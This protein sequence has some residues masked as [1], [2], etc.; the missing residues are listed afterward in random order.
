[1]RRRSPRSTRTDT[2]FPYT[3]LF[4]S[5]ARVAIVNVGD[6]RAYRLS[7]GNLDQ[8]S[9]DHS[10]V[11]ELYREGRLTADEARAHPQKNIVTRAVGIDRYVD[12]DE[13]QVDRKSVV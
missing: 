2:L 13:F 1:M 12:V 9:G 11:G 8:I 3:T 6:S 4:R 7:D 10:L 5:E